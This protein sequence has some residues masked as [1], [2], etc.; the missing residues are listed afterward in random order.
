MLKQVRDRAL[1]A[2]A[3]THGHFDHYGSSAKV[4]RELG[5]PLWCGANDVRAV[6]AG[7]QVGLGT[8]T[9]SGLGARA[10]PVASALREGDE[11]AGFTVLDVPGHPPG[12]VAYWRESDRVLI[13]GDVMWGYDPFTLRSG[14]REPYPARQPRRRA[15]PPLGAAARGTAA[16]AGRLRPR[17]AAARPGRLRGR[18]REAALSPPAGVARVRRVRA[19]T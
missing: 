9:V 5:L 12:H 17:A 15:Q 7:R 6:E 10:V 1:S 16:G 18:G 11:V 13:A 4:C 19:G 8:R 2:H 14:I 3:L